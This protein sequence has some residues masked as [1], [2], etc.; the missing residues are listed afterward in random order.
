MRLSDGY[1]HEREKKTRVMADNIKKLPH[2]TVAVMNFNGRNVI[3]G[4][5][6]SILNSDYSSDV[7]VIVVD[8]CSTDDG[9]EYIRKEFP[10]V[11][12]FIQPRNMGLNAARN[13]A[14]A[15]AS[16]D[17]IL[18]SDNDMELERDCL[19][20]LV[21]A[22]V[23]DPS[24]GIATPMIL[25]FENRDQ[26]YSDN[27]ELHYLC[28]GIIPLR[29]KKIPEN[30]NWS[31][32]RMAVGSGGMLLVRKSIIAPLNGLDESYRFGYDEGEFALRATTRG[33][34]VLY[35]PRAKIFHIE[36]AGRQKNRLRYAVGN[37]WMLI[38]TIYSTKTIVLLAP[39]L[40]LFELAQLAYLTLKLAL[41]EWFIGVGAVIKNL[42]DIMLKRRAVM[43]SKIVPDTC[44]MKSGDI[45]MF[46]YRVGGGIMLTIKS[47][48][49]AVFNT[50]WAVVR[51]LIA[52]K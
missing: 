47:V 43:E 34:G 12:V 29:H 42:P 11:K 19:R 50:Y 2:V 26:I 9:V 28:H 17:F 8:D 1:R 41:A 36:T 5:L 22:L 38:F 40:L 37:R 13:R 20:L 4:T 24:A 51:P 31:T 3:E 48:V 15:E 39:A 18:L 6:R 7:E 44:L 52:K 14:I 23:D 10:N 49:E 35:V 30:M 27:V 32:R 45:F 25:D 21:E 46:P 16:H 33:I